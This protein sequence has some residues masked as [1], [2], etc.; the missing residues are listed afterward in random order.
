M[1]AA[2]RTVAE[3]LSEKSIYNVE[4]TAVRGVEDIKEATIALEG[5]T[6]K[7]AVA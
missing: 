1:E 2:L 7:G 5:L 4:Y 6:L 3:I